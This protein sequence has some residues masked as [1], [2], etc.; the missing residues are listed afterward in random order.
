MRSASSELGRERRRIALVSGKGG[1]GKSAIA[2]NLATT[3]AGMGVSTLLVDGDAGLANA[4]LLLGLIPDR[5][6]AEVCAGRAALSEAVTRTSSGLDLVVTGRSAAALEQVAESARGTDGSAFAR[7]VR[8][9]ALTVLDL[10][11]GI[12]RG[13]VDLALDA[14]PIWLVATP[15]PT[16]LADAY[17]M[18]RRL[19]ERRP[20]LRLELVVNRASDRKEG[21]RTHLA[22]TRLCRRFLGR[23]LPLR[24]VLPE[25]PAMGRAVARQSPVVTSAPG[26]PIARSLSALAESVAEQT[27]SGPTSVV[28]AGPSLPA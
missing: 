27:G 7:F 3:V 11:A 9:H 2:A 12:G 24:S 26:S 19:W 16:S 5:T 14:D 17:A 4:D 13:V 20:G 10:G 28:D 18:A 22:L 6:L 23:E 8:G 15:E 21:T 1:V 25:D